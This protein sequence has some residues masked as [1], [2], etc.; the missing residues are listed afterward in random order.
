MP[1]ASPPTTY[2]DWCL[3]DDQK[4][5]IELIFTDKVGRR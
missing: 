5:E 2:K 4:K 1:V 3:P